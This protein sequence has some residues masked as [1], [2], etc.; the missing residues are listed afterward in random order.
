MTAPMADRGELGEIYVP[1]FVYRS[2]D[3]LLNLQL[4]G[5]PEGDPYKLYASNILRPDKEVS[6][7]GVV[8]DRHT[9]GTGTVRYTWTEKVNGVIEGRFLQVE[10]NLGGLTLSATNSLQ[11]RQPDTLSPATVRVTPDA[12]HVALNADHTITGA[13]N[14]SQKTGKL[15]SHRTVRV[16]YF[17]TQET[18]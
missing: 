2:A 1:S 5:V 12:V 13:L 17:P 15:G 16:S 14:T 11:A 4:A 6:F 18:R 9:D 10:K 3:H 7:S 8:A